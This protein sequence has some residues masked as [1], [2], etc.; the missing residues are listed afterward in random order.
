ME[1]SDELRSRLDEFVGKLSIADLREQL[2]L[3]YMQMECCQE[4]LRGEDVEPVEMMDNG[5]SSDLE[6]FYQCKKVS[7]E[8]SYLNKELSAAETFKYHSTIKPTKEVLDMIRKYARE[9]VKPVKFQTGDRVFYMNGCIREC[10]ID[11]VEYSSG[12]GWAF[13]LSDGSVLRGLSGVFHTKEELVA[14]LKDIINGEC[15]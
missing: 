14:N 4:V 12:G 2:V 3:A 15:E 1:Y 10:Y 8:L 5:L 6:L 9:R 11:G 13:T 7:E